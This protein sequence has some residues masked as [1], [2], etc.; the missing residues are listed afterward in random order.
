MTEF[1]SSVNY[2][3]AEAGLWEP[4]IETFLLQISLKTESRGQTIF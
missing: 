3:N 2:Y 4:F 1:Q